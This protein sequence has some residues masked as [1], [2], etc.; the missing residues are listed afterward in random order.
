AQVFTDTTPTVLKDFSSGE[1]KW[2]DYDAD[3]DLDLY[4][5]GSSQYDFENTAIYTNSAGTFT[6]NVTTG[7]TPLRR[8]YSAWGDLNNDGY[9]DLVRAGLQG[10][11]FSGEGHSYIAI[12]NTDGTFT[13]QYLPDNKTFYGG[14]VTM[15]DFDA[16]GD[17]DI[18][19]AGANNQNVSESR[20]Y[21]NEGDGNFSA[22]STISLKGMDSGNIEVGDYDL[23]GDI[24]ILISGRDR[25]NNGSL[26]YFTKVYTNNGN[27]N[28]SEE[29]VDIG[30]EAWGVKSVWGDID[31]DGYLDIITQGR[32]GDDVYG[33]SVS[34]GSAIGFSTISETGLPE[35]EYVD[36]QEFIDFNNDGYL[37]LIIAGNYENSDNNVNLYQNNSDMT[38]TEVI[39]GFDKYNQPNFDIGD[40]DMDGDLDVIM[41]GYN[42]SYIANTS[43]YINNSS[44]ANTSPTIPSSVAASVD[45]TNVLLS[46]STSNDSETATTAISYNLRVGST[47]D[48][49]EIKSPS[50]NITNGQRYISQIGNIGTNDYT[51][52]ENLENGTYYFAVQAIDNSMGASDFSL[53]GSFTITAASDSPEVPSQLSAEFLNTDKIELN[54]LDQASNETSFHVERAV[55]GGSFENYTTLPSN[56]MKFVDSEV[57]NE[58]SYTYRIQALNGPEVSGFSEEV[59]INVPAQGFYSNIDTVN[60]VNERFNSTGSSMVDYNADGLLDIFIINSF[61]KCSLYKNLGENNYISVANDL[62]EFTGQTRSITWGD[63]NNDGYPEAFI[64]TSSENAL[65]LNNG[66]DTFTRIGQSVFTATNDSNGAT[67]GDVNNDGYIDIY[68]ANWSGEGE[69]YLNNQDD[70]FT[71]V[72]TGDPITDGISA[73]DA[74]FIDINNDSWIDLFVAGYFDNNSVYM[75]DKSGNLIKQS[76]NTLSDL[77]YPSVG[78]SWADY[79][80]DGDFDVLVTNNVNERDEFYENDGDGNFTSV[81]NAIT[82]AIVQGSS[83]AWLDFDNDGWEDVII[84]TGNSKVL[85]RN[86]GDKEFELIDEYALSSTQYS[87]SVSIGDLDQDGFVD[88][89]VANGGGNIENEFFYNNGNSNN[90]LKVRLNG[91]INNSDGI[92]ANIKVKTDEL[93]I[94]KPVVTNSGNDGQS[95]FVKHFGLASSSTAEVEVFWP[96][97]GIQ[98]VSDVS[99]NQKI[100]VME[101]QLPDTPLSLSAESISY[102]MVE[103]TWEDNSMNELGFVIYRSDD[104]NGTFQR[105]DTVA[106][107]VASY[108]DTNVDPITEYHYNIRAFIA[109]GT[110]FDSNILEVTTLD[111]PPIAPVELSLEVVSGTQISL[112]WTDNSANEEGF[113]V[114]Q[115]IST[116]DNWVVLDSTATDINTYQAKGLIEGQVYFYRVLAFNEGGNSEYSNVASA[117]PVTGMRESITGNIRIFPNPASNLIMIEIPKKLSPSSYSVINMQGAVIQS[118]TLNQNK[119]NNFIKV[120][121]SHIKSGV[122]I[123]S[124]KG[125]N[126]ELKTKMIIDK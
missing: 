41:T 88:I 102:N 64:T 31:S 98:I 91:S 21:R 59:T 7:L 53:E 106:A 62:S 95:G 30:G 8:G 100:E 74:T 121:I 108:T 113:V 101:V 66:D 17:L 80:N 19:I 32:I 70:T 35:L 26:E 46:W 61:D 114:E 109:E 40:Y 63:I 73:I 44:T 65:F 14:D 54:W 3:G 76:D 50:S 16:D 122:Y 47:T 52:L 69:L 83:S 24:D 103:L 78:S 67:W 96:D 124:L 93:S 92:G 27:W 90:W 99:A 119:S 117:S 110:S 42:S 125:S 39:S 2:V 43:L 29:S 87:E 10:D 116:E 36:R 68:V 85:F 107:N 105:I 112:N 33:L 118:G 123:L 57:T 23:D 12:N 94:T 34:R 13:E 1:A 81:S 15:A 5:S 58:T 60:F 25:V 18:L 72:L 28:F 71:Q 55:N 37:D 104:S 45:G 79:D 89:I 86:T 9:I 115:S 11:G 77:N 120:D 6:E 49:I 4:F 75:N 20:F 82:N 97:N 51:T 38:F 56:T 22:L 84:V 126:Q 48:G 111:A